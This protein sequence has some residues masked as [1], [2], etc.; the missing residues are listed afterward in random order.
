MLHCIRI[1]FGNY[2]RHV[3]IHPKCRTVINNNG[4]SINRNRTKAF[5]D[6]SS[7][8]K[9]RDVDAVETVSSEFLDNVVVV[10]ESEVLAGGALGSEHFDGSIGKATVGQD[11][12]ELLTDGAGNAH[13]SQGGGIFLE[14]HANGGGGSGAGSEVGYRN[15]R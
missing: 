8:A 2:K 7:G 4:S 1:H 10:L 3:L 9:E 15:A 12:E 5:T 14:G 13:D 11:G 6:G